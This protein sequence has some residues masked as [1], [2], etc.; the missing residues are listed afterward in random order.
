[1]A[2]SIRTNKEFRAAL[3][4][5]GST[6]AELQAITGRDYVYSTWSLRTMIDD[7]Y[8]LFSIKSGKETRYFLRL[9]PEVKAA[10]D[11]KRAAKKASAAD[12]A[13]ASNVAA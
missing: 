12:N 2:Q 8:D 1:M 9:K 4:G 7:T 6:G 5:K 10:R 13:I 3:M 11:A